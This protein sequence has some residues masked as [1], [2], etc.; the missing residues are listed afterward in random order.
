MINLVNSN[1]S[2]I[3]FKTAIAMA[4]LKKRHFTMLWN[5]ERSFFAKNRINQATAIL[6]EIGN[7]Q[8]DK[9]IS[10]R[11]RIYEDTLEWF[12]WIPHNNLKEIK[13]I[14]K[15]KLDNE[16]MK[17]IWVPGKVIATFR[18][19]INRE[20][21]TLVELTTCVNYENIIQ[22]LEEKWSHK[23]GITQVPFTKNFLV[24]HSRGYCEINHTEWNPNLRICVNCDIPS[25]TSGDAQIDK[26]ILERQRISKDA[27]Q[28][29]EWIPYNDLSEIEFV[30]HKEFFKLSLAIW[31][32]GR[33]IYCD[34]MTG[35]FERKKGIHV[36]LNIYSNIEELIKKDSDKNCPQ[37]YGISKDTFTQGFILVQQLEHCYKCRQMLNIEYLMCP[38][39]DL[40]SW[41]SG[42]TK[43]DQIILNNQ[44]ILSSEWWLEWI[45]YNQFIEIEPIGEGGFAKVYKAKW[46]IGYV[47]TI[48]WS[49]KTFERNSKTIV[50][51]KE[52]L[53]S[54]DADMNLINE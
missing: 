35:D 52:I 31:E 13:Y 50:A 36:Q 51:L 54:S 15:D 4:K 39:C 53:N 18:E 2:K 49:A 40:P 1:L 43:V 32:N 6:L 25:W 48:N 8:I 21:N 11:Q 26:F 46:E 12:E 24:V 27:S 33:V 41:S 10:E 34:K 28:W 23:F 47:L 9:L 38:Q 45:P 17:A 44:Q 19:E 5:L 42:N 37:T 30:S 22:K 16:I 20:P 14:G 3:E 7:A 29:F